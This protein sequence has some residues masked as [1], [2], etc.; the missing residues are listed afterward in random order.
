[1]NNK[2]GL[3]E[4]K[5]KFLLRL[6]ISLVAYGPGL[7]A[8]ARFNIGQSPYRCLLI[9][10]PV[11]PLLYM[12]AVI[13]RFFS[14]LDEPQRKVATE[15]W[16]FSGIATALTCI[17]YMFLRDMGAPEFDAGWVF[18]IMWVYFG[19]GQFFVWRRYK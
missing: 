9:L 1:M 3:S 7:L 17:G 5:K 13:V 11:L 14:E 6:A 10:F 8:V 12:S 16:A 18:C 2:P 4:S 19:I 15:A